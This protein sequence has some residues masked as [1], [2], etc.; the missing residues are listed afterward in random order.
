MGINKTDIKA[1][2]LRDVCYSL[3][4]L[5]LDYKRRFMQCTWTAV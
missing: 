3:W 1:A 5:K 4:S 2:S